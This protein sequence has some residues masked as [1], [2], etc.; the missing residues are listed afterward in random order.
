VDY[1]T[2]EDRTLQRDSRLNLASGN[3]Q[4]KIAKYLNIWAAWILEADMSEID[5]ALDLM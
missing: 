2:V 1:I 4:G 5:V 3:V